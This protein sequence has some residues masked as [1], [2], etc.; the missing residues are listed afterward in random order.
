MNMDKNSKQKHDN[1]VG[2][3]CRSMFMIPRSALFTLGMCLTAAHLPLHAMDE[4]TGL[5]AHDQNIEN[6]YI[7]SQDYIFAQHFIEFI[8]E[9]MNEDKSKNISLDAKG[10]AHML[11]HLRV[12]D[13]DIYCALKAERLTNWLSKLEQQQLDPTS[14]EH[15]KKNIHRIIDKETFTDDQVKMILIAFLDTYDAHFKPLDYHQK[16]AFSLR[17][18][19]LRLMEIC[20]WPASFMQRLGMAFAGSHY[21]IQSA[22]LLAGEITAATV[23]YVVGLCLALP[24]FINSGFSIGGFLGYPLIGSVGGTGGYNGI[25]WILLKREEKGLHDALRAVP[26]SHGDGVDGVTFKQAHDDE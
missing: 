8:A 18:L 6:D 22:S 4:E 23:F 10:A 25:N 19:V 16:Q 21:P 2:M 24:I 7:N 13:G 1:P 11:H 5:D 9:N 26:A 15:I 17:S 12:V 3:R 20:A 14:K